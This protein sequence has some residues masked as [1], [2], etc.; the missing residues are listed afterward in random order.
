MDQ[1]ST[2][3]TS[4][5]ALSRHP[6]LLLY[7]ASRS[8]SEFSY[9]VATVAVGWQIYALTGSAFYLGLAGLVQFIPSALLVFVAGHTADRYDRRRIMQLCELTQG[10]AAFYLALRLLAGTLTAPDIFVVLGLFGLAGAFESP[11]SSALL[12]A[13]APEGM[14]QRATA[15]STGSWQV[16]AIGGPAI[17]G[18]AYAVSPSAPFVLMAVLSLVASGL[19]GLIRV[20]RVAPTKHEGLDGLFAGLHFVRSNP[21]ILGTISLDLFAVLLG[22]AT[23]LLPIYAKDILQ[24]GP[25]ALGVMRAAPAIGALVMTAVI[26]R[27]PITRRA[28]LRMFQAVIAFG[29][30]TIVFALS[31]NVWL[32]IVALAA[33][34]AADTISV[35]VRVALVQLATPDAMRGR[36]GAVNFLFINASNQLGEFESGMAAALLG[37]MPAA[38]LGGIGTIAIALLWM[39][40]FPVLR[41]VDQLE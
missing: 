30:A 11:A 26:A 20:E 15:L 9:Q 3:A 17:G 16:A 18:L 34:G 13:V 24:A 25:W 22:G 27:R 10:V 23:A 40:L 41:E 7:I 19:T 1:A 39:K 36:V 33:M 37:A 2:L 21:A 38:A 31:R 6:P 28:G 32:S 12:P 14:L 8:L 35:V 29:L 4:P 5:V